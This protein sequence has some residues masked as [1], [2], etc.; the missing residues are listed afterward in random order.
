MNVCYKCGEFKKVKKIMVN[1]FGGI[2]SQEYVCEDCDKALRIESELR[3]QKSIKKR[4][5]EQE[6]WIKKRDKL[7]KEANE[8]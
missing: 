7:L 8:K 6:K 3:F 1:T 2:Y 4:K 5:K